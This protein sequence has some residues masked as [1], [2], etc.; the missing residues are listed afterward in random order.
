MRQ[1]LTLV[2]RQTGRPSEEFALA[3]MA[4]AIAGKRR[5]VLVFESV[6]RRCAAEGLVVPTKSDDNRQ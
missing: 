6:L 3:E 1:R 2:Y 5:V 4:T